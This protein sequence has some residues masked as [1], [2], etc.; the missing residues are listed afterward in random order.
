MHQLRRFVVV[1][2]GF[3]ILP[4]QAD[5]AHVTV[6]AAGGIVANQARA[7]TMRHE[8]DDKIAVATCAQWPAAATIGAAE[9]VGQLSGALNEPNTGH[10]IRPYRTGR[11]GHHGRAANG[12]GGQGLGDCVAAGIDHG[13][14]RCWH[15]QQV[16][17]KMRVSPGLAITWHGP[18]DGGQIFQVYQVGGMLPLGVQGAGGRTGGK[19]VMSPRPVR[20]R[21]RAGFFVGR[22]SNSLKHNFLTF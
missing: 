2:A 11:G 4:G 15:W 22:F 3:C 20:Y 17:G 6:T 13:F 1:A 7:A 14:T 16:G 18:A 8:H 5:R 19:H 9:I 10:G 12:Q 21:Y